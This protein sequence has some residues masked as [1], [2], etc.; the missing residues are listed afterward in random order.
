MREEKMGVVGTLVGFAIAGAVIRRGFTRSEPLNDDEIGERRYTSCKFNN[1]VSEMTFDEMVSEIVPKLPRYISHSRNGAIVRVTFKSNSGITEWSARIGFCEYGALTSNYWIESD[2]NDSPLPDLLGRR[3]AKCLE[4]L[5]EQA[6]ADSALGETSETPSE[7][8]TNTGDWKMFACLL[9]VLLT[10]PVIL[11]SYPYI[12]RAIHGGQS[13]MPL[14]S[15]SMIGMSYAD[16]EQKLADAGFTSVQT[17]AKG[18]LPWFLPIHLDTDKIA[19]VQ[20][21][22]VDSFSSGDWLN[23]DIHIVLYYHSRQ[24]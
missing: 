3:I 24:T 6:R 12:E 9:A 11:L 7:S 20:V 22:G 14:S 17:F 21:N 19:E 13:K 4:P 23:S 18:D 5:L 2:N 1:G 16:V 8:K 15:Q 10:M